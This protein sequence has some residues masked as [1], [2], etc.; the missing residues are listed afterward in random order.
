MKRALLIAYEGKVKGEEKPFDEV[1]EEKPLIVILGVRDIIPGLEEAIAEMKPGE[2]REVEIPPEKAFGKRDPNLIVI[3]P[4]REFKKRGITPYPGLP[5]EADGRTGRVVAVSA[6]RVQV[7]FNHPL[8]GKTLVYKVKVIDELKDLADIGK[9]LFRRFFGYEPEKVEFK[10]GV[11]KISYVFSRGADQV[12]PAFV[13][14][15]L[16]HFDEV[17]EVRM[18]KI[19][20]RRATEEAA[21]GSGQA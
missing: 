6:G 20:R 7:D 8:A 18:E 12:E 16:T 9:H 10:D 2:E 19:Y 14:Y 11:L 3:I 17:K 15:V 5:I 4:E 13:A 21:E 1:K